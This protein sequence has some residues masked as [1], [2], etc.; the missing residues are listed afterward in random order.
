MNSSE[1]D[2]AIIIEICR[3]TNFQDQENDRSSILV[4]LYYIYLKIKNDKKKFR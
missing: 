4:I 1:E 2:K 3:K